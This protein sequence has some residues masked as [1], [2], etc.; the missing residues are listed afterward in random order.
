MNSKPKYF[1]YDF[2]KLENLM[3]KLK[4]DND[5][6]NDVLNGIRDELNKFFNDAKCVNVL[7]NNNTD[8]LFFGMCVMPS[9]L[10]TD[11]DNIIKGTDVKVKIQKYYVEIDSKILQLNMTARELT[12]CLLHEVGHVVNDTSG[13]EK[14]KN[15]VAAYVASSHKS[16]N[17]NNMDNDREIYRMGI[18]MGLS[19]IYSLF[20]RDDD[21]LIADSFVVACGYGDDLS[22]AYKK[23][24]NNTGKLNKGV[25]NKLYTLQWTLSLMFNMKAGR[26]PALH[27]LK[28]S[29]KVEPS[30]LIVNNISHTIDSL[31]KYDTKSVHESLIDKISDFFDN[32]SYR[33]IRDLEE[34]LCEYN[35]RVK[36]CDIEDDAL[37][38]TRELNTRISILD[39]LMLSKKLNEENFKKCSGLKNRYLFVRDQ[40]TAKKLYDGKT[41]S[42]FVQTPYIK[43]RP[44][45]M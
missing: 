24:I 9:L 3:V 2:S 44:E 5:H 36:N 42:I 30:Q 31:Y 38:I 22:S 32:V 43:G 29:K 34:E 26:I 17:Q 33:D 10:D 41:L 40:L 7:Y 23:I 19:K 14:V 20:N 12:A 27:S 45:L 6:S 15:A 11:I 25:K 1:T 18:A 21:E 35:I 8:K 28:M 39:D 16:L 13:T 37:I 4:V